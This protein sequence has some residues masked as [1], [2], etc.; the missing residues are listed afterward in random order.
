MCSTGYLGSPFA[1]SLVL[2]TMTALSTPIHFLGLYLILFKT[3]RAMRSVKWYL[4]NLHFWIVVLDYSVG[5]L[6]IPVL[7]LP[8]F[9]VFPLGILR[10]F[11][12]S[13]MVQVFM[14]L[15]NLGCKFP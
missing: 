10:I 1:F 7:L 13:T 3:P 14:V 9:A 8:R 15:T 12:V 5:L 6:T 2:H 4:L 11:G